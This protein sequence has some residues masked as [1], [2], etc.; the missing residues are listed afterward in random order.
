MSLLQRP[1]VCDSKRDEG[2]ANG[3][4]NED[5]FYCYESEINRL[6]V[7]PEEAKVRKRRNKKLDIIRV[8]VWRKTKAK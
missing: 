7:L 2:E 8:I 4:L 6:D 5:C 1:C 3:R